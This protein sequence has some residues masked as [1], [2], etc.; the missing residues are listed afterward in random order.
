MRTRFTPDGSIAFLIVSLGIILLIELSWPI[1]FATPPVIQI[2]FVFRESISPS[3][4]NQCSNT[5]CDAFARLAQAESL[6]SSRTL[7]VHAMV[8]VVF[9]SI[10]P[11][12]RSGVRDEAEDGI[13]A[14]FGCST[15]VLV[16][17]FRNVICSTSFRGAV[18]RVRDQYEDAIILCKRSH[19][20][21][22]V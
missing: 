1:L 13:V 3:R 18:R 12:T 5:S 8:I 15:M 17:L 21:N 14:A 2:V 10:D 11:G 6:A 4:A 22:I 7:D 20:A 19:R 9:G 16:C